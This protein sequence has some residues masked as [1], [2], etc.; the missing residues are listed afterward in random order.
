[1]ET[2]PP[3]PR[4]FSDF[5]RPFYSA[6][7]SEPLLRQLVQSLP[8]AAFVI[9]DRQG[10]Y[11]A[12]SDGAYQRYGQPSEAHLIGRTD[13]DFITKKI[14]DIYVT[15]DREV[16]ETGIPKLGLVEIGFD[17]NHIPDWLLTQKFPIFNHTGQVIGVFVLIQSYEG[18]RSSLAAHESLRN[19]AAYLER[20]MDRH[21]SI[22]ELARF[23][24]LS[25]RQLQRKFQAT[26]GMSVQEF[27]VYLRIQK[28]AR[29]LQS[30]DWS[31]ASIAAAVGF[32][33]QS[34]FTRKFRAVFSVPP[35]EY[36]K[37]P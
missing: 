19:A 4:D 13:Y 16:M 17:S 33:D 12:A 37:R 11:I 23:S 24:G 34:A 14:A 1:M 36:R 9:K 5:T 21:V 8:G 30:S 18:Q 31:V 3:P 2:P 6:V 25:E 10:R 15:A 35:S 22:P 27:A 32:S 26:F 7:A 20:H 28:A 29:L